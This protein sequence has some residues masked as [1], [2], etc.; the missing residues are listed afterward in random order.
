M[1]E[2][3]SDSVILKILVG[4]QAGVEVALVPG[5]YV[6]GTGPEDDIQLIDVS[7]R[8]GHARLRVSG[9]KIALAGAAGALRTAAGLQIESG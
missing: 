6:L 7:I 8:P 9:G 3:A 4:M 1:A 5:E 2:V